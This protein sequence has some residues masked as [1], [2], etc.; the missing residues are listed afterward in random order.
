MTDYK[1]ERAR[2]LE[3]RKFNKKA[4]SKA[5]K[6]PKESEEKVSKYHNGGKN[7]PSKPIGF[8][9][10][11]E[12]KD[13]LLAHHYTLEHYKMARYERSQEIRQMQQLKRAKRVNR[14]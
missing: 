11:R 2:K 3:S 12:R 9:P 8:K 10:K 5:F 6:A 13:K 4:S 1:F 7:Y 14:Y